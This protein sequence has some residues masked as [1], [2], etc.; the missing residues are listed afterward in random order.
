MGCR[1]SKH[2]EL[3]WVR[4]DLPSIPPTLSTQLPVQLDSRTNK[5]R[6]PTIRYSVNT[7]I[8][9]I[10]PLDLVSITLHLLPT[11]PAVSIRSASLIVE[12]RIQFIDTSAPPSPRE[13][14]NSS[15][16][17][18]ANPPL[19]SIAQASSPYHEPQRPKNSSNSTSQ[20]ASRS[21]SCAPSLMMDGTDDEHRPLLHPPTTAHTPADSP[22][23]II[24]TSVAGVES[25]GRFALDTNGVWTKTLTFQ[26]PASKSNSRWAIGETIQSD[27]VSVRFFAKI[28]VRLI[29]VPHFPI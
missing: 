19:S 7:S 6:A 8:S 18:S 24:T 1:Q 22:S 29:G 16:P 10:G 12:R 20:S 14:D 13:L 26:W 4:Y 27:M 17:A 25:S 5:P 23:K 15:P 2:Y 28:K 11:E 3:P 21:S 9:P